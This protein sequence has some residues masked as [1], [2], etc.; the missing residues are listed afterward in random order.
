MSPFEPLA[1][2][3]SFQFKKKCIYLDMTSTTKQNVESKSPT[4]KIKKAAER[5][6]KVRGLFLVSGGLSIRH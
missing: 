6:I 4:P 2:Y 3:K 5:S 1:K